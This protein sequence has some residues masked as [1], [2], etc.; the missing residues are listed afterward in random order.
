MNP[1]PCNGP[2]DRAIS[3]QSS[4]LEETAY[5]LEL[6]LNDADACVRYYGVCG[7]IGI[8]SGQSATALEARRHDPDVRVRLAVEAAADGRLPA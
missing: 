2:F 1:F 6:A 5:L 7:L 4:L 8:G 3:W